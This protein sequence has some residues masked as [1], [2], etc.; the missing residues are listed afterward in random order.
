MSDL[1]FLCMLER[2][3]EIL[4]CLVDY[5]WLYFMDLLMV[6]LLLSGIGFWIV[7]YV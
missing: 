5:V 1:S 7:D 2:C 4:K 3:K 6:W